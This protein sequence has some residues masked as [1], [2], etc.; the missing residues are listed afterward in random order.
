MQIRTVF[1]VACWAVVPASAQP[2]SAPAAAPV[3]YHSIFSDYRAW[4]EPAPKDWRTANREVGV[5]GGHMGHV[6]GLS[7][8]KPA[9]A[10]PADTQG[11]PSPLA[12]N[13]EPRK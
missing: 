3:Q 9:T 4:R 13:P 5:L 11:R 10:A 8:N 7:Q 12:P 6:R 2:P 1:L